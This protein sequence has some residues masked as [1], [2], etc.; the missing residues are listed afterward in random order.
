[1]RVLGPDETRVVPISG[2][3]AALADPSAVQRAW[4]ERVASSAADNS[5]NL[6]SEGERR[7]GTEA[8]IVG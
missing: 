4:L 1:M 8:T 7:A 6:F 2:L 5:C 3:P